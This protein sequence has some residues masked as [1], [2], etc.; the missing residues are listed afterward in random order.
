MAQDRIYI[1]CRH[2]GEYR[3]LFKIPSGG[4]S[5]A[6]MQEPDPTYNPG[7]RDWM[8]RHIAHNPLCGDWLTCF[9]NAD[10]W[11]TL[12][13]ETEEHSN[14]D[15]PRKPLPSHHAAAALKLQPE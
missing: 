2:C 11:F 4:E 15:L 8:A 6:M 13:T 14:T 9:G 7:L 1:V 10:Q 12:E 5:P 3:S